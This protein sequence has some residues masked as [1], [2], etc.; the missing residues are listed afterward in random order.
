[1]SAVRR[2]HWNLLLFRKAKTLPR[3]PPARSA[4]SCENISSQLLSNQSGSF[5]V[6]MSADVTKPAFETVHFVEGFV[7]GVLNGTADY[8]GTPH[9]FELRSAEPDAV[10]VYELTP[11]SPEVFR[12]VTEAWE[13]WRRWQRARELTP[14]LCAPGIPALPEDRERQAAL[15][16]FISNWIADAKASSFLAEGDFE[17]V[18]ANAAQ[19]IDHDV[20]RVRWSEPEPNRRTTEPSFRAE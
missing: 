17:R 19:G 2:L 3:K 9:H 1:M 8:R 20:L 18:A 5:V 7:D 15:R 12:A 6:S 14:A 13:I 16:G 4:L 10:E 11:L